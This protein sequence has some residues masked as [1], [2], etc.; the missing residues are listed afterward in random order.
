LLKWLH[1]VFTVIK[2]TPEISRK[3]DEE[4]GELKYKVIIFFCNS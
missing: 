1:G 2:N 3:E 4:S